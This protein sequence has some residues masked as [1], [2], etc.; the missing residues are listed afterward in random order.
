MGAGGDGGAETATVDEADAVLEADRTLLLGV[1]LNLVLE[2][3]LRTLRC[4]GP[5]AE[6][7]AMGTVQR[8]S[9]ILCSR[10]TFCKE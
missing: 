1:V 8:C 3:G 4:S 2:G 9:S 6:A 5:C 7:Q 10:P